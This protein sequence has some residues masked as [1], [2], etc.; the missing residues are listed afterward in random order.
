[1]SGA[2]NDVV[3]LGANEQLAAI[4][5]LTTRQ[6]GAVMLL[7]FYCATHEAL[8]PDEDQLRLITRLSRAAWKR[9]RAAVLSVFACGEDGLWRDLALADARL[10]VDLRVT[11]RLVDPALSLKR[12]IAGRAGSD[13]RWC[14]PGSMANDGKPMAT[15]SQVPSPS[16]GKAMANAP[17]CH[18]PDSLEPRVLTP[19]IGSKPLVLD[20]ESQKEGARAQGDGKRM[21]KRSG[22]PPQ[23]ML[24]AFSALAGGMH[25]GP[26][27][28]AWW[29][30]HPIWA[31]LSVELGND[32]LWF[33]G[34]RPLDGD[35]LTLI[36]PAALDRDHILRHY[37]ARLER[38]FGR[39]IAVICEPQAKANVA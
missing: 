11:G 20:I 5:H 18:T 33:K 3:P 23:P 26:P 15:G 17:V 38:E 34:C 19:S 13:A 7:R 16:D 8:P 1:M 31:E 35:A 30:A 25:T 24:R 22:R 39:P 9:D 21:A 36:A 4:A 27:A 12:S 29:K 6:I 2:A 28:V 14:K 32:W 10:F 37:S